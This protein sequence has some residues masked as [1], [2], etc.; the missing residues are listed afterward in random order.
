MGYVPPKRPDI[1][2]ATATLYTIAQIYD[3]GNQFLAQTGHIADARMRHFDKRT[4][5]EKYIARLYGPKPFDW[6]VVAN[7]AL[8][9]WF[10]AVVALVLWAVS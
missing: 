2:Q 8:V 6:F 4:E 1:G 9:G 7:Y 3:I 5:C 10:A